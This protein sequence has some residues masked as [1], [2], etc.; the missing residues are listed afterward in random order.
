M[1]SRTGKESFVFPAST[2]IASIAG[3]LEKKG[4]IASVTKKGK[5]G[6]LL[7]V[8]LVYHGKAPKVTGVKRVSHLSK[9]V[10]RPARELR[11]VRSGYG[12]AVLSTPKGILSDKEARAANV[13]GEVLFE[14]W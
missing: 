3:A 12:I 1:A 8:T 10:Y 9:R 7:E 4:Y 6:R 14:I 11:S 13:G 5:K 2:F